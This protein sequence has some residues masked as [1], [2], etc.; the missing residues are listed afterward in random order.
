MSEQSQTV[1]QLAGTSLTNQ[2]ALK[3]AV[4]RMANRI[5]QAFSPPSQEK[6]T[7]NQDCVAVLNRFLSL[8][9][10]SQGA[11]RVFE[12]MPHADSLDTLQSFRAVLFRLGFNTTVEDACTEKMRE[13]YLPCFLRTPAGRVILVEQKDE[14]G[15]LIIFD[16]GKEKRFK[17]SPSHMKGAVIFPETISDSE[18]NT[19]A[20]PEKWSTKA[21][22]AFKPVVRQILYISFIINLFAL[23]PPLYVMNVYDKAIGS[24]SIDVLLG[25]S[26]GI[27]FIIAADY[28][29]R[30]I[31]VRLQAYLGGRLDEQL[32]EA[33]FQHL[34][35]LSLSYTEDAPIGSQLTRLRQ[36]TSLHEAFTGPMAAALFDLP[37][38]IL[39]VAAIALIGGTLVWVPIALIAAYVI[40]A[41]WAVP[42]NT[43]LV[44]KAGDA[45][46]QLN[47]LSVE[48]ISAQQAIKDLSAEFVWLRRHRRIS[49]E[50]SMANMKARQ[51]NFLIQT[52]SQSMVAIAGVAILAVGTNLVISG[53]LS[54]GA[55]I[56][57]MA[58][59]WRVLG[60]I[61]SL[62]LSGLTIGQT[63]QSVEQ[64]DR[65]VR[66]PLERKPNT[67]PSI[68]RSFKG[69]IVFD[70]VTFRYPTQREPALR[71]I[72]FKIQPGQ[73]LCLYG[74]SGSGTSTVLSVLMGLYQQQAGSVFIDGL[75]LRQLDKGEWRHSI[76]VGLQSLDLFHG[77]IAQ[78]IRLAHPTATDDDIMNI[79]KRFGVDQYFNGV[80]NEG[81][82][83]RYTTRARAAWPDALISR[84]ILCRAFVKDAPLY[85]LDEPAI[86]LDDA[87]EQ[88]LLSVLEERRKTSAIIMT[89]QRPSHMRVADTVGWMNRGA[90][91]EMG[92][93]NQIV[94]KILA[95]QTVAKSG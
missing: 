30:Q 45:K 62:F 21:W 29:L 7:A 23:A 80:L 48:A 60:P 6:H 50:A 54:A 44:R 39:F 77:T 13:E 41:V 87:G 46:S 12:S 37:F 1:H 36:M 18:H 73:L 71:A 20:Q 34:L 33:A 28:V 47:N 76:G 3:N 42:R 55:L 67:G 17:I 35:H 4:H 22:I 75:D 43:K 25:L 11:R 95:G 90:L 58:L 16:P 26:I 31:R 24:K 84:I 14:A 64:V 74:N 59:G 40:M 2:P 85:L 70:N 65:L 5:E 93:P 92:P 78:N 72:S 69:N 61:R 91:I 82:E 83:T 15:Q 88:A 81:I 38:I 86:T 63:I 49:A 68:P 51:F 10:W 94:P 19:A 57:V 27:A 52:F 9:G 32:N 8:T 66:M 53:D 79:I 89:T 56:A